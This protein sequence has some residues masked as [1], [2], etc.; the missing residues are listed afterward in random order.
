MLGLAPMQK[1][2]TR[3]ALPIR[4]ACACP[5]TFTSWPSHDQCDVAMTSWAV[6]GVTLET[7]PGDRGPIG[8]RALE[9]GLV[10]GVG[11]ADAKVGCRVLHRAAR[12]SVTPRR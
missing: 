2:L 1:L 3:F 11:L 9:Q 12:R 8:E 6:F 5:G 4:I 7:G 10:V